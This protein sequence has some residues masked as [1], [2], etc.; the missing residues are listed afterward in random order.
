VSARL[1]VPLALAAGGTLLLLRAGRR[2]GATGAEV[3]ACLP[4][5]ALVAAPRWESTRATTI[6]APPA[7]VWP[8]VVQMGF[9]TFRAG[10]Y[11]PAW[12]D[13]LMWRIE[14]GSADE[15][16]PELQ[17]LRVGDR[18]PDS[19][20]WSAFFTVRE[21]DPP[22]ALV[23][24]STRHVLPPVRSVDFTWAFVLREAPGGG[25]RLLIRARVDYEPAWAR[26]F[27]DLVV[28]AGDWVNASAMLRGLRARA[29]R[30][31]RAA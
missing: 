17:E 1:R 23:L 28:G 29:E 15:I 22:R 2:S 21:V 5:D 16:R 25:T 20:D 19:A 13:R 9:P 18:V 7:A 4:G 30:A 14:A 26:P 31:A 12:L 10:W 6:A 8:W 27:V 24:H 3:R 11:T